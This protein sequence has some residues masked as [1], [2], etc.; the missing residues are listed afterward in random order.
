MADQG[1]EPANET[2]ET[3]APENWRLGLIMA[4]AEWSAGVQAMADTG[5]LGAG[6][7]EAAGLWLRRF[8]QFIEDV[9]KGQ[10]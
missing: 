4:S 6:E 5:K 3:P 1:T 9:V 10:M 7:A 8:G 2:P